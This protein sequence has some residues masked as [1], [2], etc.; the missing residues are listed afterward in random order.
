MEKKHWKTW[1]PTRTHTLK[2]GY[3]NVPSKWISTQT[4][5]MAQM[6]NISPIWTKASEANETQ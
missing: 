6:K 2:S 1:R 3:V 5:T 4:I